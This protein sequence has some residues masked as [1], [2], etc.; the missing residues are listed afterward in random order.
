M[1]AERLELSPGGFARERLNI[2]PTVA[3]EEVFDMDRWLSLVAPPPRKGT[4]VTAIGVDA[5]PEPGRAFAIVCCWRLADD[6]YHIE[7]SDVGQAET[8]TALDWLMERNPTRRT[9]IVIDNNSPAADLLVELTARKYKGARGTTGAEMACACQGFL[10]DVTAG[11]LT[12]CDEVN[13]NAAVA[14]VR[15]RPIQDAGAF[16][17]DRRDGSVF[18]APL[19]AATLAR[20]GAV[21]ARRS[22]GATF[23]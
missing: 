1:E 10:N 9:P 2:W 17:W 6:R 23:A 5:S 4:A 22:G 20:F 16:G 11:R 15:K 21:S 8:L 3:G 12:H 18:L 14:G 19:V 13:L 7:V